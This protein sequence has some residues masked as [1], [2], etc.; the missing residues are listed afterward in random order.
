MSLFVEK[1]Q[2]TSLS[3]IIG[4]KQTMTNIF[5]W[6][7]NPET[8]I[9]LIHGSIGIGKSLCVKLIC[10]ELNIQPHY[11]D[12]SFENINMNIF[13]SLGRTNSITHK[14][15]YI[16]IEE[17]DTIPDSILNEIV[18]E[19]NNIHVPIICTSNTNYIPPI[20]YISDKITN[21][22]LFPP[23][24]NE[25][26]T[27]LY[28][29]LKENNIILKQSELTDIVKN[30]NNDI[31]FILN[32]IEMMSYGKNKTINIKDNTSMNM[33]DIGKELFNMDKTTEEKYN[34]FSI[35]YSLMPLFIQENYIN[36]T[37]NV[38]N[39]QT[40]MENIS[41]S[42]TSLSNS[43]LFDNMLHENNNWDLQKYVTTCCVEATDKCN[44][45]LIKFPEF[46]KKNKKQFE[47]YENSLKNINYYYPINSNIEK[48]SV[49]KKKIKK[50]T[51]NKNEESKT[52]NKKIKQEN[53]KNTKNTNTNIN[54]ENPVELKK[55]PNKKK[56]L[57]QQT[58]KQQPDKQQT[59]KQPT[60]EE[61]KEFVFSDINIKTTYVSRP[62]EEHENNKTQLNPLN[63]ETQ[64]NP[65]K[66]KQKNKL[67]LKRINDNVNDDNTNNE[68]NKTNDCD[69]SIICEC[70]TTIK[71]S[72]KSAHLKSKKHL[73]LLKNK[74]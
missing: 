42:S 57:K 11:I 17:I 48:L 26:F 37:F 74:K 69:N 9:C 68:E 73:D 72:S 55:I 40:K 49:D 62:N 65:E 38:K 61:E 7:N 44:T 58:D 24:D 22:K 59:D 56:I 64:L 21:F 8:K 12:N 41:N 18:K 39:I 36:N 50:S 28:P 43:D 53:I 14:K 2:P 52:Q 30:C 15:N 45:K 19:I 5:N 46:F 63:P 47:S 3:Q 32:T 10:Q 67:I 35:D 27:F 66:P 29:I 20:K 54:N 25:I 60:D 70:G 31:R 33:F 34:L 51:K 13:K 71:K 6:I 16:I 1:Y 23:Y 4:N